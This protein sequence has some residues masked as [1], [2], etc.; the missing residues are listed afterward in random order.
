MQQ[1]C[2]SAR[3]LAVVIAARASS[4][5]VCDTEVSHRV[6]F[7]WRSV[8][9]SKDGKMKREV[10][11]QFQLC[12]RR[13]VRELGIVEESVSRARSNLIAVAIDCWQL[14]FFEISELIVNWV[15]IAIA[16]A[17]PLTALN[18]FEDCYK[19]VEASTFKNV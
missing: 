18:W 7:C 8:S 9:S 5:T 6:L 1:V 4:V 19:S 16:I 3:G 13:T 2:Q 10:G 11:E 17:S 12:N 15:A 14:P